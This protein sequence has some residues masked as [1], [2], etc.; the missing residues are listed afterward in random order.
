MRMG[1]VAT[2]DQLN[3]KTVGSTNPLLGRPHD[4]RHQMEPTYAYARAMLARF[5]TLVVMCGL[6]RGR[7]Q[8][9]GVAVDWIFSSRIKIAGLEPISLDISGGRVLGCS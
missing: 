8:L 7:T 4:A 5:L 1:Y 6:L 3:Q 9:H 2:C